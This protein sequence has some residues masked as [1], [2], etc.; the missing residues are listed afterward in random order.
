M[1]PSKLLSALTAVLTAVFSLSAA[2]AVPI[3]WRG[4]YYF[5]LKALGLPQTTGWNEVT[6]R[7]AF[8][9]VMDFLVKDAPF[10]TGALKWSQSGMSHFSDCKALFRLDFVVLT[11]SGALLL[12]FLLCVL[13]SPRFREKFAF[14]PPLAALLGTAVVLLIFGI[15]AFVDFDGLFTAF[16]ALCFPGKTNWIFDWRTDQIILI[17]PERFWLN[18]AVL[19]AALALAL[20]GLLCLLF[21]LLR[22]ALTPKN[23]YEAIL[24]DR[25]VGYK[26]KH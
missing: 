16:H 2:I 10:G 11:V 14:S 18:T 1:K 5:Q 23:V 3:L 13:F 4:W 8:D 9:Q 25:T 15:W 12:I 6:I 19:I 21:F 22:R 17:L 26:P 20:E 7:T 24:Q